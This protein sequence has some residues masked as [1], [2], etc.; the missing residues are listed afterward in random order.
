MA[1]Y[2]EILSYIEA[3]EPKEFVKAV[4]TYVGGLDSEEDNAFA[5]ELAEEI[6]SV[7][8]PSS[9]NLLNIALHDAIEVYRQ[10]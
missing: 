5:D 6:L 8:N 1:N 3:Q 9:P 2:K 4:L 10:K 7:D